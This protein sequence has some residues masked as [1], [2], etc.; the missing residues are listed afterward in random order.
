[1]KQNNI[2]YFHLR[3]IS[4]IIDFS[5]DEKSQMQSKNNVTC[6]ATY[7]NALLRLYKCKP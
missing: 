4:A 7:L 6:D 2:Y 5:C 3:D 1:M